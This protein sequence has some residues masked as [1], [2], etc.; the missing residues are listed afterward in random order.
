MSSLLE[1]HFIDEMNG[2]L[3]DVLGDE[4]TAD[5]TKDGTP[6]TGLTVFIAHGQTNVAS[7]EIAEIEER[8]ARIYVAQTAL[9]P[10]V[11]G[12]FTIDGRGWTVTAP[13]KESAGM[14]ECS[15]GD[16]DARSIRPHRRDD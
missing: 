15:C 11:G 1:Q 12:V 14:W 10:T 13:P 2:H 16:S 7:Q 9:T 5:Y 8:E 4:V 3:L 6:T